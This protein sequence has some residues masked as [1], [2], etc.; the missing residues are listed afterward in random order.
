MNQYNKCF[1][2]NVCVA[3]L[4]FEAVDFDGSWA[5]EAAWLAG[6]T[7]PLALEPSINHTTMLK[8]LGNLEPRARALCFVAL[9]KPNKT[10]HQAA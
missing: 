3:S 2:T 7:N 1:K 9:R 4:K 8:T 10:M 5:G 6:G